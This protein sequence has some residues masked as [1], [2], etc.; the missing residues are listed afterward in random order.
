MT[1]NAVWASALISLLLTGCATSQ[2]D[3]EVPQP[4]ITSEMF[5]KIRSTRVV[6]GVDLS[7]Q[8]KVSRAAVISTNQTLGVLGLMVDLAVNSAMEENRLAHERLMVEIQNAVIN[9]NF[10]GYFKTE[11]ESAVRRIAW[12]HVSTVARE[13]SPQR[14]HVKQL[15]AQAKEDAVLVTDIGYVIAPDLSGFSI[16]A[17]TVFHLSNNQPQAS[18]APVADG[19]FLRRSY[20]FQYPLEQLYTDKQQASRAWAEN[21][22]VM[23]QRALQAGVSDTVQRISAD[24]EAFRELTGPARSVQRTP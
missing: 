5:D 24:L 18:T 23:V 6:I 17:H 11:F 12:L 8:S 2:V 10:G 9:F 3:E 16:T 15:A 22:G 1:R 19:R 21:S 13:P 14:R 4:V 20:D 7:S